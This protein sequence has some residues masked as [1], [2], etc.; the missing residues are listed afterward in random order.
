MTTGPTSATTPEAVIRRAASLRDTL[1]RGFRDEAVRSL[2]AEASRIAD[3]AT[4]R[5]GARLDID[6]R[7]DALVTSPILGLPIMA[8]LLAI[9]FWLTVAGANV[10]SA[11][12]AEG[13]FWIEGLGVRM[14]EAI[15]LPWWIT[16]FVWNGVYRGL[17]WVVSV[18]LPPMAIFFPMFTIL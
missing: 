9:V 10:P 11:M 3:R 6:Q 7:I 17:A 4:V 16:G 14:F 12:L 13:L 1:S 2:Y 18:M 5:D 8:L 15:G